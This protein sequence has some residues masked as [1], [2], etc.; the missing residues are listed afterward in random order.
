MRGGARWR[1]G[2][3][4][5]PNALRRDRFGDRPWWVL[6]AE[7]YSGEVPTFPLAPTVVFE[8]GWDGRKRM[9]VIDP[10]A[11]A[12]R[13]AVELRLWEELWRK[14]QAVLW[15]RWDLKWEVAAYV[16]AFIESIQ[17]D[18]STSLKVIV[19]RMSAEI[20]LSTEGMRALRWRIE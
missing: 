4:A 18:A 3:A 13:Q 2:P 1:S 20:G 6:P 8:T 12:I 11:S 9:R 5:D 15:A 10:D 7:G 19:L 14:P 16:R 17:N